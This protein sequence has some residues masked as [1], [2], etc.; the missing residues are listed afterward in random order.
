MTIKF[1]L[2]KHLEKAKEAVLEAGRVIRDIRNSNDLGIE[3]KK[4]NTP[5]TRADKE[6]QKVIED[7][8]FRTTDFSDSTFV[9]E[10]SE[11]RVGSNDIKWSCDPIDG[12]ASFING[13]STAATSLAMYWLN[14]LVLGVVYNPF[15]NELYSGARG[16][17]SKLN[18][19]DLP[20]FR[21]ESIKRG[22]VDFHLS[23]NFQNEVNTLYDLYNQ[24][25]IGKLISVGGSAAYSLAQVADGSHSAY[26]LKPSRHASAW[27]VDAGIYL[28]KSIGGLVTDLGGKE[29]DLKKVSNSKVIIA[30]GN[31][32][33]HEEVITLLQEAGFGRE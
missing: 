17:A 22:V 29:I 5:V 19:K 30:S 7:I 18:G 31:L 10:E 14:E 15:T 4:D 9:G 20:L 12:T 3:T 21:K 24:G 1:S 11:A 6:A 33:I 32:P 28:V 26:I 8:I 27:D 25:K 16:I 23:R 13:E 2:E